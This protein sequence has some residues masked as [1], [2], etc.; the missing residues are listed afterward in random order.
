MATYAIGDIQGCFDELQQLLTKIA[1]DPAID[2]LWFAGDLVNRGPKSLETLRYIKGLG[3]HA[4]VV[5]G[6]HDL[7][8][9]AVWQQTNHHHSRNDT[10]NAIL[11][12]DDGEELLEWL[13]RRPL[14]HHDPQLGYA[15][16]HAGLPPQWDLETAARC[17]NEV[18]KVLRG[19]KFRKFLDHMYG[20]KPKQWSEKLAGWERLRFIV[21]CFTRLRFCSKDGT[22]EL[23]QKGAPGSQQGDSIPWFKVQK[24]KSRKQRIIFGHWSTLGLYMKKRVYSI[25]TGCLWGG[26]LTALQIDGDKPRLHQLRCKMACRPVSMKK[27]SPGA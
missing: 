8:L 19:K 7:H 24:R 15:M 20:N 26:R 22:L 6:N 1:F 25:D 23:N 12:A 9:L 16:V 4:V 10:L 3:S 14:F 27:S 18:E 13:R 5:L 21:N 17:A 11:S 2:T